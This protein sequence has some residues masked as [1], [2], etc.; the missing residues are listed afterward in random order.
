[1]KFLLSLLVSIL[2]S[3]DCNLSIAEGYGGGFTGSY[4]G[5]YAYGYE[6][7]GSGAL[8]LAY[9]YYGAGYYASGYYSNGYYRIVNIPFQGK[10][11]L[12]NKFSNKLVAPTPALSFLDFTSSEE[13][14]APKVSVSYFNN[15]MLSK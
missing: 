7:I 12:N 14:T 15:A 5:A 6:G 2:I 3:F 11:V 9:G 13:L 8:G 1:M 4:A 10:V